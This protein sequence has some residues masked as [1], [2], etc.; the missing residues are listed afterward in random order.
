MFI[1]NSQ[2]SGRV[3]LVF[4]KFEIIML[5]NLSWTIIIQALYFIYG[6]HNYGWKDMYK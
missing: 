4:S 1:L 6:I 5:S 3:Q 2:R